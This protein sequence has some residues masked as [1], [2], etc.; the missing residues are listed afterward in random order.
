MAEEFGT[1]KTYCKYCVR[2]RQL[3]RNYNLTRDQHRSLI[4]SQ[5]GGCGICGVEECPSGKELAVDHNHECC[6]TSG[7]SCGECVRGAL[8]RK[9]NMLLGM[10][11]D[12]VEI[13]KR[14][15]AY[16]ESNAYTS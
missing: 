4:R 14:A 15:V 10:V 7:R 6:R 13:L 5:G 12:D 16:L 11:K 2:T 1:N 8:C 3:K 9:C